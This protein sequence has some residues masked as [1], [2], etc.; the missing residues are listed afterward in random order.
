M[1]RTPSFLSLF[2]IAA[3]LAAC[4]PDPDSSFARGEEAFAQH[5][6]RAARVALIAGLREKPENVEMRAMLARTQIA[7]GDGEGAVVT[8]DRLSESDRTRPEFAILR[9]EAEILRGRYEEA[10]ASVEGLE[11][12]GADRIRALALLA[13]GDIDGAAEAFAQGEGRE[14]QD[15]RLLAS[16]SRFELARGDT[17]R[18][19]ALA[20]RAINVDKASI[21]AQLAAA[22]VARAQGRL[23]VALRSYETALGLHSANFEARLGKA[24]VLVEMEDF[25]Q[26]APLVAG[27]AKEAPENRAIELLRAKLAARDEDWG[28]VRD[29][30]QRYEG[31]MDESPGL[32]LAYG[33]AQLELGYPVQ[34]LA[35]LQP[36]LAANPSR[37]DLRVLVARAHLK[38]GSAGDALDTIELVAIRPD[39]RPQE[40]ALASEAAKE[41]GSPKAADYASRAKQVTPQWVGGELAKAD[42]A[43]RNRQWESAEASYEA[44]L[45]R[46]GARN[47]MVLN[48]LAYAK[49]RLGK[50]DEGLKL[51][52]EAVKASPQNASILDTAGTLLVETGSRERGI[53]M[54]EKAAAL[55]PDNARIARR[56]AAARKQ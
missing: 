19:A 51:A 28:Q 23:P 47:A 32:R 26:A 45:E 24:E 30:L 38:A 10:A 16:Y 50:K 29:I 4:S 7:L 36:M 8:L 2:A 9:G 6:Y 42:Q 48:N 17:E 35:L 43:L 41:L 3:S 27:L 44:I 39:A 56:L 18:A 12:A 11:L 37:R 25:Q 34:S 40:L 20:S 33:E 31:E 52:L 49:S 22:L 54:L 15:P 21:E 1:T 53:R 46:G 14:S 13:E 55:D 5:D